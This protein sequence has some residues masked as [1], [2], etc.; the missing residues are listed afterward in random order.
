MIRTSGG[1]ASIGT[2]AWP[3]FPPVMPTSPP[4]PLCRPTPVLLP[5]PG[6]PDD[7]PTPVFPPL[8]LPEPVAGPASPGAKPQPAR[9]DNSRSFNNRPLRRITRPPRGSGAVRAVQD[10]LRQ[11]ITESTQNLLLRECLRT[12][13]NVQESDLLFVVR[14]ARCRSAQHGR[15]SRGPGMLPGLRGQ[16]PIGRFV[17]G[18]ELNRRKIRAAAGFRQS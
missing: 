17:V 5:V 3:Q 16:E 11:G 6:F 4:A 8:P 10:R 15:L 12:S 14:V 7:R 13:L 1:T 9:A 18:R 2:L